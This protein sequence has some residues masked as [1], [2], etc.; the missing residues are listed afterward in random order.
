MILFGASGHAKVIVSILRS[1]DR[2]ILELYDDNK[3]LHGRHLLGSLIKGC[4]A[5]AS[6]LADL[7]KFIAI[8]NNTVRRKISQQYKEEVWERLISPR[9]V[10]DSTAQVD[11]GTVIMPG[12]IINPDVKIGRHCIINTNSSIDHD[13]IMADYSQVSPGATLCGNVTVGECS[14]VGAGTVVKQGIMIG[15]NVMIG[16]GSVVVKD[17]PDNVMAYGSPAR[18]IKEGVF[19]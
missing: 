1:L 19:V 4:I 3:N 12:V 7:P 15:K 18:I 8:G 14:Y 13:C 16:A 17:I 10:V 2:N 11:E 6:N 9:A 5:D